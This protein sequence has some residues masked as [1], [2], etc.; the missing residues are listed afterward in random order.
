LLLFAGLLALAPSAAVCANPPANRDGILHLPVIDKHDLRFTRLSINGQ[1]IET[2]I[3]SIVQDNYGFLWFGTADGLYKYDGYTL[4]IYRYERGNPNS[5]ANDSIASL[6]KDRDGSIW[7]G[8]SYGGLGR[9]DPARDTFTRYQHERGKPGSLANDNVNCMYRDR[10]GEL[11]ICTA[12]GLDRFD[13]ASE[14]FAHYRHNERDYGSI[15]GDT[16]NTI[17]EDRRGNLWVGTTE[18]L[19][20]LNRATGRFSR[21]LHEPGNPHSIGHNYVDHILED[22]SGV[23]WVSSPM[24]SGLSALSQETG[25]FTRYSFHAEEPSSLS[26]A[27]VNRLFE[28]R[29]G[30]LWVCSVDRGLLR[31]DRER[32]TF[33]RYAT[34][35]GDPG[36]LPNNSAQALFEDAEGETWVATV[37]GA[38]RFHREPS[39]F[40]NYQHRAGD[41]ESL[42]NPMIWSV[43]AD[44]EGYVWIGEEDGLNRLDLRTGKSALFQHNPGDP[45]S[46]SYNIV[47]AI[48]ED[49]QGS[50][51]FATYGGGLDRFDRRSGQFYAYRHD[52]KNPASLSSD[53]VLSL[54]IDRRGTLWVGTQ[55]GGLDSFDSRTGRF[56][57]YLNDTNNTAL[58][59]MAL[60]EDRAGML[61]VGTSG[62]GLFRF[63]PSSH[64]ITP[65]RHSPDNPQSLSVNKVNA[66]HEDRH[67][68]MW[69]GTAEGLNLLDVERGTVKIFTAKEGLPDNAVESI[70]EDHRGYL[71]LGTHNGLSR[72][73]PD[74]QSFHNYYESDGLA[75]NLLSPHGERGSCIMPSG[76][77]IFGSSNGATAFYP[78]RVSDNPYIAPLELT[79]FRLFNNPV[80]PG[81]NSPL[82]RSIWATDSLTLTHDQSILT[83]G[84][85]ALS[86]VAPER[87]RY[88][89]R[90]EGLETQWN[91][92]DSSRRSATYTTLAAGNYVFRVQGSNN[93]GVWNI[94]GK[95][96][97]ITVLP[98]WWA[99]WWFNT[100]IALIASGIIVAAYRSRLRSLQMQTA[101]LETQVA[102][103]TNE[104]EIAKNAAE[105]ANQAKST[106]LANMS[107]ELRTPL[108]AILGFS[109]LLLE[110]ATSEGQR[111]DLG[112]INRSGEHLLT[113]INDVLDMAKIDAGSIAIENADAD[114]LEMITGVID[115]MRLRAEEKGLA[116]SFERTAGFCRFVRT[117]GEKLRQALINLVGNAVKYTQRGRVTLRIGME[118]LEDVRF[119]NLVIEVQ[120]TG[121][122]IAKDDQAHIF[123]AFVQAG[124]ARAQKGTGLG[125]AITKK[126]I[127]LMGGTIRVE[128]TPGEGSLFRVRVPVLEAEKPE[129]PDS[130]IAHVRVR[131]LRPDQPAYRLLI[132]ED[133]E[134]NWLLLYQLLGNA[135]FE[136]RVATDGEMAIEQFRTWC[137]HFIWMD[138]RL[139]TI[140][141]LETTRRIR[142]LEGGREVKIVML[143]AFAFDEDRARV[144]E[145]GIDDFVTKPFRTEDVFACLTRHL[146]VRYVEQPSQSAES[147]AALR[148]EDLAELPDE[149]RKDLAH[150]VISLDVERIAGV[151]AR[152]SEQN[153]SL[154][155]TLARLAERHVYSPI[156]EALRSG[157]AVQ[158]TAKLADRS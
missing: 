49:A 26:V 63:D 29:D 94:T 153:A 156:F 10:G 1:P 25:E 117:D 61:W 151:I 36:S 87:N 136:T 96:L 14:T 44:S 32:K 135:G 108:N 158:M 88:R 39:S 22:R 62:Q 35:P 122:G 47:G 15:S 103:R 23:L 5:L 92:V 83:V 146:G 40:Q 110:N 116:L 64:Q 98:P 57:S 140:D 60:A 38:S 119:N 71:W 150:A 101:R 109:N 54:L 73:D 104:L 50:L 21:F 34:E 97:A 157:E 13:P 107:H 53:S 115:L 56:T 8:S 138:W 55:G 84:F 6:F 105:A 80:Q 79:E 70:L 30:A 41:P 16:I 90:L 76:E 51:W 48:R 134:E 18:G 9:L 37:S 52:P 42:H 99:T 123:D 141:G 148:Q 130:G 75:G 72:F 131:R 91:E 114:L 3:T 68:R 144:L 65:F 58:P 2:W 155:R 67:G 27:G 113:L 154:G 24:G 46:L 20:K 45:H 43:Q 77:M 147:T 142:K 125:L 145:A 69:V 137:P 124:K 143:S 127:E 128:S 74:K 118:P 112:I 139:P 4:R 129:M 28:D 81:P 11:W 89:Y 132:V 59:I 17:Y 126:Y 66:I 78:N 120:D 85:S 95:A 102:Q 106:F 19:N 121:I 100:L 12:G 7:I 86:Y 149:L 93:D 31:L 111:R 33:F 82:K 152:I 133:Q